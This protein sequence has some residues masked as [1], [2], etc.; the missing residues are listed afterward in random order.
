MARS[1][2]ARCGAACAQPGTPLA[3]ILLSAGLLAL[4]PAG[5]QADG[6]FFQLDLGR[7]TADAV[8]AATRG[9]LSFGANYSTYEGGWSAGVNA[10][11]N[12]AIPQVATLKLG[13]SLGT[14]EGEEGLELGAKII[15]ER[16]QPTGFGFAFLSGQ[17]NTIANDWFALVQLGNAKGV[18]VDFTA[19]GSDSYSE[20]S[21]ALNYRVDEGPLYLRASYRF[22]A[23][24]AFVGLSI[25]T[26]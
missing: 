1:V 20:Q 21:I 6:T 19:G 15:V 11:R 26:F 7:T 23:Q 17:Y 25:N 13:P 5:A 3:A 14:G 16:Y 24:E 18:S 4:A 22:E 12:F 10:T 9:N 2:A 8:L